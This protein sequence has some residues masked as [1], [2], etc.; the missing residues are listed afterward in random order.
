MVIARKVELQLSFY[1]LGRF[2]HP[3]F[4]GISTY[5]SPLYTHPTVSK[6]AIDT[7]VSPTSSCADFEKLKPIRDSRWFLYVVQP[8]HVG[9]GSGM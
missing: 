8:A 5:D 9:P 4:N 6:P 2:H 1:H 3:D 7:S